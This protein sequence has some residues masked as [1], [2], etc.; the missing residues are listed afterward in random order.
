[1]QYSILQNTNQR[2]E[3][4]MREFRLACVGLGGRGRS[5]IQWVSEGIDHVKAV[6]VCDNEPDKFYK[7]FEAGTEGFLPPLQEKLPGVTYYQDYDEMLEKEDLDIIMVETPATC[8]TEFCVKALAR[9]IH[10][11]S[12]IPSVATLAEADELWKAG[13]ASDALLMTGATTCG[14]G[15]IH[16]MQDLYHKGLLGEPV[17]MEAEY[18]HDC[19]CLWER[20]P[21]RKPTADKPRYPITYCTHSLGPLLSILKEDLKT[22]TCVSTGSLVTGQ[23][24]ANDAMCALY[25]T[26]SGI[27]VR[28]TNS[29]INCAPAGHS[30]RVFGTEGYFERLY[31]R[32]SQPAYAGFRSNKMYGASNMTKLDVDFAPLNTDK[33][34]NDQKAAVTGHGGA[35]GYLWHI[36]MEALRSGSKTAPIGIREGLRMT[37]PGIYAAQSAIRNGQVVNIKYPWDEDWSTALAEYKDLTPVS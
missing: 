4:D 11:Y 33:W 2:K 31:A 7:P 15:F 14:W 16:A 8:H 35:D 36:F 12:D 6:A 5:M 27:T 9:N 1:M 24:G 37:L 10:V 13:K 20:T 28:N 26:P 25:R 19:R 29:F 21:W 22:V 17:Y 18:I 3:Q 34:E 23:P 30:Y 32:H